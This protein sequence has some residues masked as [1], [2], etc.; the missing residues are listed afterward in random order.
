MRSKE[1]WQY[2]NSDVKP[3]L[4]ARADTF[5]QMFVHLDQFDRPVGIIETGCTREAGN[6]AGDGC[7]TLLFDTYA[8]HHVGS[9]IYTVDLDP[10]AT[11]LCQQLVSTNVSVHTGDSVG[12]LKSL[13]DKPPADMPY[14]DLLYLDSYDVDFHNPTLSAIHH[15][16]EL[17]AVIPLIRSE[18]LVVVDDSPLSIIAYS[19]EGKF[20][21]VEPPSIGGKGKFVAE[22][23]EQIGAT[24]QFS[25]YQ[26]GWTR[27][28]G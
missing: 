7:S 16:K 1:F 21:L 19:N 22:Y 3:L 6:W 5:E 9:K 2:F 24:K 13:A 23:A 26:C 10:E 25:S 28:R 11:A 8:K 20:A 18:T 27:M 14:L 15:L 17:V 4:A 12:Y